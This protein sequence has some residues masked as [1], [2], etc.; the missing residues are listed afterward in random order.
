[1]QKNQTIAVA[2]VIVIIV[3]A[4]A[5]V[6]V[7][8]TEE[9]DRDGE[10]T[11]V[12]GSGQTIV[13]DEP[14]T[15]VAVINS[16]VPKA[17][18]ML[19]L[20]DAISCYYYGTRNSFD[21]AAEQAYNNGDTN[22]NLG[23]YYTP[24]VEVLI[25]YGVQ[26]V[27]C[28]VSSM[29]LYSS[30]ERACEQNGIQV[31]RLDCNG[32]TLLEDLQKL[33]TV[34]GNPESAT[35]V[36]DEYMDDYNST[37]AAVAEALQGTELYDYLCVMATSNAMYNSTSAIAE[38]LSHAFANNVTSYTDLSTDGVSNAINDGAVEAISEV[39]DRIDVFLVRATSGSLDDGGEEAEAVADNYFNSYVG[40]TNSNL[41]ITDNSPAY[42]NDQIFVIESELMSGLYAHIGLVIIVNL[43]Y[44]VEVEGFEDINAVITEFQEK[45][46]QSSLTDGQTLVYQYGANMP[47]DGENL[48]LT[49]ATS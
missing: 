45:F 37:L 14:L 12:D 35:E 47:V 1:M 46:S 32:D 48:I 36:L 5:A 26:A 3:V 30:V 34:F 20:D 4:A 17:M 7:L 23:T 44:G 16:N 25:D 41:L 27:I 13:L 38:L 31:I 40:A 29:T 21:I 22:R 18:I 2:V 24:S 9:T 42:Q 8:N 43:V 19:G 33:S 39:M 49:Y 28:P 10:I 6:V 15:N 11:I